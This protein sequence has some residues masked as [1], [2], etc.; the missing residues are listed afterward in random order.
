MIIKKKKGLKGYVYDFSNDYRAIDVDNIKNIHKY[1]I[2]KEW[3]CMT[4]VE[5]Y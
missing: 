2:K 4:N 1:L 3:H 5:I